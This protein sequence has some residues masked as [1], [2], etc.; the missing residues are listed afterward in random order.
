MLLIVVQVI[1]FSMVSQKSYSQSYTLTTLSGSYQNLSAGIPLHSNDSITWWDDAQG[2]I[3]VPFSLKLFGN[4]VAS[5]YF[6]DAYISDDT[7]DETYAINVFGA[8]IWGNGAP[9]SYQIT[10]TS[11]NRIYKVEWAEIGF[12][13]YED[14]SSASIEFQLWL[15]ETSDVIEIHFGSHNI[16]DPAVAYEGS[17]GPQIN[18]SY[19]NDDPLNLIFLTGD[20]SNPS[21]TNDTNTSITGTPVNGTIFRFTPVVSSMQ[22]QKP[23]KEITIY[24]VNSI[25]SIIVED[26]S[27]NP[28]E[29]ISIYNMQGQL[30]Y[31]HNSQNNKTIIPVSFLTKGIYFVKVLNNNITVVSKMIKK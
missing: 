8:N 28:D 31:Q 13:A 17:G 11:P 14:I 3:N 7:L 19:Y 22:E 10:G 2:I 26:K 1:I 27:L 15:Y 4:P 21:I 23:Q 20:A 12:D 30:V 24:S 25:N 16:P 18:V 9:V 29:L 5:L 6:Y